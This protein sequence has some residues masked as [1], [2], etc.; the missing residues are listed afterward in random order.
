MYLV[1]TVKAESV[2]RIHS[3]LMLSRIGTTIHMQ[4]TNNMDNVTYFHTREEAA[5]WASQYQEATGK[6]LDQVRVI[7][8]SN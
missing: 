5:A 1:A 2:Y 6:S 8:I 4:E 3:F 7:N